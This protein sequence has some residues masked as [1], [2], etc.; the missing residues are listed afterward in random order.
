LK[1]GIAIWILALRTSR[2]LV[3]TETIKRALSC[4]A[5][6]FDTGSVKRA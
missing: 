5:L 3:S 6:L 2:K 1:A 4:P